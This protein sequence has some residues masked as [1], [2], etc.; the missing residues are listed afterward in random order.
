[1][2]S[3]GSGIGGGSESGNG[4]VAIGDETTVIAF[5]NELRS[6]IANEDDLNSATDPTNILNVS[7]KIEQI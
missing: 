6:A 1:M 3:M 5:S 7:N 2:R 4:T